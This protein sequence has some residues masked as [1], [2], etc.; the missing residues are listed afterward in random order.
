MGLPARMKAL[1]YHGD[2]APGWQLKVALMSFLITLQ[3]GNFYLGYK[4][5]AVFP[6]SGY[7]DLA[8]SWDHAI[9]YLKWTWVIYYLGFAYIVLW[10]GAGLWQLSRKALHRS[11]AIYAALVMVGAILH[12]LIPTEAP[13][14]M[15]ED[16]TAVQRSFKTSYHIEPLA[17][18]PSMHVALAVL[19]AYI[20]LYK[21]RNRI[22]RV[23]SVILAF[24]V[25]ASILTAKEHW[26]LDALSGLVLGLIACWA[27]KVYAYEPARQHSQSQLPEQVT[28]ARA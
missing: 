19:P 4:L 20:S 5:Y 9:P 25:S 28:P 14:P 15:V 12:L 6:P 26:L 1:A 16:L 27:W 22:N 2:G 3:L 8:T 7:L 13:W 24:A 10:G 17:C 21:F 11:V 23:L 18:F